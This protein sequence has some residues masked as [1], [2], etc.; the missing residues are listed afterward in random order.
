MRYNLGE[1]GVVLRLQTKTR[2]FRAYAV[3]SN[4]EHV[5]SASKVPALILYVSLATSSVNPTTYPRPENM[6][7]LCLG[8]VVRLLQFQH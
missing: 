4:A 6:A 7:N 3:L 2:S 1:E 5:C 8:R